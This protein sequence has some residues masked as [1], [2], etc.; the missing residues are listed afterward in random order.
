MNLPP[1]KQALRIRI[2]QIKSHVLWRRDTTSQNP[3]SSPIKQ[4]VKE[5]HRDIDILLNVRSR[6]AQRNIH[7]RR[8]EEAQQRRAHQQRRIRDRRMSRSQQCH[9]PR[10]PR[11][12]KRGLR[13]ALHDVE[14]LL[15]VELRRLAGPGLAVGD[16][17]GL[18]EVAVQRTA[19]FSRVE[20][21]A[22]FRGDGRV[23]EG[24][25]RERGAEGVSAHHEGGE[26]E[27]VRERRE[28]LAFVAGV[29]LVDL[30][31]MPGVEGL[32]DV[33][34][35]LDFGLTEAALFHDHFR[36]VARDGGA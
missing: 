13:N 2:I 5:L 1:I 14:V 22:G 24:L 19:G 20:G 6:I 35:F 33:D 21:Q 31:A 34:C 18:A 30:L 29:V 12:A 10:K 8:I 28:V 26:V 15:P 3:T 32:Q 4:E 36:R 23:A 25:Q 27:T 9:E 16:E 7:A 17:H 11:L